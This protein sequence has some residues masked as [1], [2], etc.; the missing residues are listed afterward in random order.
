[1]IRGWIGGME[2]EDVD[3]EQIKPA[4]HFSNDLGLDSL[5]TVEVVMAIEEVRTSLRPIA[6]YGHVYSDK[7]AGVQHRDPRQGGRLHPHRYDNPPSPPLPCKQP[8]MSRVLT[9][10]SRPSGGVHPQ[11]ARRQLSISCHEPPGCFYGPASLPVDVEEGTG[12]KKNASCTISD[13]LSD[14]T[15]TSPPLF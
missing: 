11:A 4:A 14:F 5:D 1:M 12:R 15:E 13:S 9:V 8:V 6:L 7:R 3:K 2:W 10:C